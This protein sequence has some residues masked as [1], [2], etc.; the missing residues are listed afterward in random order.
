MELSQLRYFQAAAKYENMSRAAEALFISQ[1][2]LSISIAKLE[3]ELGVQLFERRRGRITLNQ[4]GKNFLNYVDKSLNI[5][6]GG[7]R[8]FGL[9]ANTDQEAFSFATMM[10][11]SMFLKQF[12]MKYPDIHLRHQVMDLNYI[13][14]ALMN[15]NIE[16]ALTDL[17][18]QHSQIAFE[19]VFES[20]YVVLMGKNHPLT[21]F[22]KITFAQLENEHFV[23]DNTRTDIMIAIN[24]FRKYGISL[25]V[26]YDIR[27][28]DALMELVDTNRY[29]S[30][31][32]RV[33]YQE[34]ALGNR[35]LQVVC[36]DFAEET[37]RAFWGVSYKKTRSISAAGVIFRD[38]LKD[39]FS[40]I[41]TAYEAMCSFR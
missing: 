36:R 2:N 18:P 37:P 6:D 35:H 26:D 27:Y 33:S 10:A 40:S 9:G 24:E 22:E 30:F 11:E 8:A 34:A 41:G 15:E 32:P 4:N 13:T 5:L 1:P 20:D 17:P 21:A 19:E 25:Q 31:L 39:Y 29:I 23:F 16:M 28:L 14:E 38:F 3:D 7:V 12:V